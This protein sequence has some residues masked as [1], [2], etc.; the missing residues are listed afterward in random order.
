MIYKGILS[1]TS[2]LNV[3]MKMQKNIF[4]HYKELYNFITNVVNFLIFFNILIKV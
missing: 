1:K 3:V 4:L 2:V